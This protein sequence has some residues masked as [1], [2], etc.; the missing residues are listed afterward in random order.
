MADEEPRHV[1]LYLAIENSD[2]ATAISIVR[3]GVDVN[4]ECYGATFFY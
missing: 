1:Q 2:S 4:G 3:G